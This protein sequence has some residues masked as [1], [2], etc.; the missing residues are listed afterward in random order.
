MKQVKTVTSTGGLMIEYFNDQDQRQRVVHTAGKAYSGKMAQMDARE[1][2][3]QR[4]ASK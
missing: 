2:N 4:K 3:K 1:R